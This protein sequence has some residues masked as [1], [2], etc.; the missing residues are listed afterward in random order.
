MRRCE[1]ANDGVGFVQITKGQ[2]RQ[3]G[4]TKRIPKRGLAAAPFEVK[5]QEYIHIGAQNCLLT[6]CTRTESGHDA[7][8]L[9]ERNY[10]KLVRKYNTGGRSIND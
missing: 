8:L 10:Q 3:K 5:R 9:G 2:A 1:I 6:G 7:H 4:Y